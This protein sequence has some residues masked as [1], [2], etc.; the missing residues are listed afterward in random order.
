MKSCTLPEP[1]TLK[2]EQ[3]IKAAFRKMYNHRANASLIL[4]VFLL[5]TFCGLA[6]GQQIELKSAS[7]DETIRRYGLVIESTLESRIQDVLSPEVLKRFE[8]S[9]LVPTVHVLTA[10]ERK[11]VAEAF[12]TLPPVHRR[13]LIEHLRGITF[14][15]GTSTSG[16]TW[17]VNSG[18]AYPVYDIAI[19]ASVL[20]QTA[21]EWLTEKERSVFSNPLRPSPCRSKLEVR[22]HFAF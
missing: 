22:M 17:T 7:S 3:Q 14:L 10:D 4:V 21:T 12:A 11:K 15:E 18:D 2:V 5:I 20:R 16:V 6:A 9:P 13:I 19:R 1:Q 8:R